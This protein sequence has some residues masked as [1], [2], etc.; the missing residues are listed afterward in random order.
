MPFEWLKFA[1]V[2]TIIASVALAEGSILPTVLAARRRDVVGIRSGISVGQIG[3]K[4]ANPLAVISIAFGIAAA[5]T[6]QIDLTASWLV[7][8]YLLLAGVIGM[9]V[10]GG[11][12]YLERVKEA[13][14]LS[15]VETP[16]PELVVLL[17]QRW[18]WVVSV[19]PPL[20]MAAIVFLMVV[21][22]RL[23]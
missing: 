23:W 12:R 19:V 21:K 5:L 22:P 11:F 1:H 10:F 13:A 6:G 18:L 4:V 7:A 17:K 14:Q 20:P 15:P 8:T 3:E 2:V 16:S 9:A